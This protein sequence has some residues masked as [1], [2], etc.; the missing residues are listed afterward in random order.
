M[1]NS[2]LIR[3]LDPGLVLAGCLGVVL[4]FAIT[5]G[6]ILLPGNTEWLLRE[7]DPSTGFI[8]WQFFR[9]APLLQFPF[10]ANPAYGM[11]MGS[12][13]V[14]TDSIPLLAFALKPLAPFL[15]AAFQYWGAWILASFVL[16][17]V[18]GYLLLRRFAL[19]RSL[20]LAGSP[21]FG[22]AP[23]AIARLTG[24]F[25]LFGQWLLVAALCLYFTPRWAPRRW[26]ALLLVG[27]LVHFYLWF[28]IAS[29]WLADLWQ[30][31]WRR[32]IA[33]AQAG[34]HVAA[35]AAATLLVFWAAGY[36]M[37]G[38]SYASGGFGVLRM[39]LFAL[40]D[41][42]D[43]WS[44]FLPDVLETE[45]EGF[46]YLGTGLLLLALPAALGLARRCRST[47]DR[48]V[49]LPLFA[50]CAGLTLLA[51]SDH[52][53]A[54][55][56]ELFSYDFPYLLTPYLGVLRSSGRLFWPV[57]YLLVLAILVGVSRVFSARLALFACLGALAVQVA[58]GALGLQGFRIRY[59]DSTPWSSPMRSPLWQ[60]LGARYKRVL[61]V[62]PHNA[63]DD[64]LAWA[65]FAH[66]HGM[67]INAGYFA[68]Y[69][70]ER[71]GEARAVLLRTVTKQ[72]LDPDS[73]YV[74]EDAKLWKA[75]TAR[76]LDTDVAGVLDGFRIVAPRLAACRTCDLRA[77]GDLRQ[78]RPGI[79]TLGERVSFDKGGPGEAYAVT[80][81]SGP[82]GWGTWSEGPRAL[83]VFDLGEPPAG[84]LTLEIKAIA[85]LNRRS[86]RQRVTVVANG[87]PVRSLLYERPQ[88]FA[89]DRVTI[90]HSVFSQGVPRLQIELRFSDAR[91]PH[92]LGY[93]DDTRPLALGLVSL[94]LV[95][96]SAAAQRRAGS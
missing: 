30:R 83:L 82:E 5:G 56:V 42:N 47:I 52:V 68:R 39:N 74:F 32:E 14:F 60:Q 79:Y 92:E 71:L 2:K 95:E 40:V 27:G 1:S 21:F 49:A 59:V 48:R 29:I 4:F 65:L 37:I 87:V 3:S 31:R 90:P 78:E 23:I 57:Y 67:T 16:Q 20:A 25:V 69:D 63:P 36:F 93:S 6:S 58:D 22:L 94:R 75:A 28:M 11:A 88:R 73:L 24:H 89:L 46:N 33:L 84:D 13:I 91:S 77:L 76:L 72:R 15:P 66:A 12:S 38:A 54:G 26:L 80:G 81:W 34:R 10:G 51:L 62:L 43:D 96:S 53:A 50:A 18:F 85:Y 70:E 35:L 41:P 61:N 7:Q 17:C 86:P 44:V 45:G 8:G 64:F 19:G 55:P 9:Q